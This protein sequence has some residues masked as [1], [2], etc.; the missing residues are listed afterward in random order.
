VL[1]LIYM[2]STQAQKE[3]KMNEIKNTCH[4]IKDARHNEAGKFSYADMKVTTFTDKTGE[5]AKLVSGYIGTPIGSVYINNEIKSG[6]ADRHN[7]TWTQLQLIER[8]HGEELDITTSSKDS[9]FDNGNTISV[10][11]TE[12][13]F[14]GI[15]GSGS[16][17][18]MVLSLETAKKM[19]AAL[20]A[21]IA[22]NEA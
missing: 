9:F 3:T 10:M 6:E 8:P 14:Y 7:T 18:G 5:D 2:T 21:Q 15:G 11:M 1:I 16:S 17:M 12:R 4:V 19:V 20:S 22:I 13:K